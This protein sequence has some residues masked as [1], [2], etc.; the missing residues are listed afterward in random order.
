MISHLL[1]IFNSTCSVIDKAFLS[2]SWREVGVLIS[3]IGKWEGKKIRKENERGKGNE[4]G[5]WEG[6]GK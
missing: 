3:F 2:L 6:K 1:I 4:R 5:K